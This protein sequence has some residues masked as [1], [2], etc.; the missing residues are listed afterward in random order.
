MDAPRVAVIVPCYDEGDL[1]REA[2]AS[3]QEDEPVEI[4]VV[5]DGSTHAR[6]LEVLDELEREGTR[7]IRQENAGLSAARMRGVAET[8]APYVYPLDGDDLVE[9]GSLAVL[10]DAL[11]R[12]PQ[13]GAAWGDVRVFGHVELVQRSGPALDPWRISYLNDVTT[14][15]LIRREALVGVG[16]WQLRGGYEDWDVGQALALAGWRGVYVPGT[17][18]RHYRKHGER[19]L[20]GSVQMHE[21]L[22]AAMRTRNAGLYAA[23]RENRRRS[24]APLH[25]K[26]LFPL[27]DTLPFVSPYGRQR[28][29][30]LAADPGRV[31]GAALRRRLG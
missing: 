12:D 25:L 5:H 3:V 20:R 11:D 26:L 4:V 8:T 16:G 30:H 21:Q 28:L 6:T 31:L 22:V 23:R 2:V 14:G 10:A 27:I 24:G 29:I 18:T 1:V 9:P 13:A 19:M 15:A 17:I 7:V